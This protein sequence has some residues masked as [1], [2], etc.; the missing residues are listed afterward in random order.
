MLSE[1]TKARDDCPLCGE[2]QWAEVRRV[3]AG[4]IEG[5]WR[6]IGIDLA[7]DYPTFPSHFSERRCFNCGLH[8][9]SPMIA[10][11]PSLYAALSAHKPDWYYTPHKWE[12]IQVLECLAAA[13]VAR[14]LEIGCGVGNFLMPAVQFCDHVSG[15]ESNPEAL[16]ECSERGLDVRNCGVA[17][18][19]GNFDV[20]VSFQVFEHVENPKEFFADC[21]E[22]LAPSGRLIVAVPNQDGILGELKSNF[23]NLPPHHVTLWGKLCFE[24][25]AEHHNLT[26]ESYL[27]EPITFD[28]YA[29]HSYDLLDKLKL[30]TG[31]LARMYN[32]FLL[33]LHR[34]QLPFQFENNGR[35]W[36]G[37]THIAIFRKNPE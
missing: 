6:E 1:E 31:F 10:G 14:L 33:L 4:P 21:V 34:A 36:P 5:Y 28:L 19:A 12:F 26:I 22:R 9:F 24:Y 11:L 27:V 13:P 20:I 7:Q 18:L 17:D 25:V 32:R 35:S 2:R 29:S 16:R 15:I 8:F 30:Q 3:A 37:H 23:L